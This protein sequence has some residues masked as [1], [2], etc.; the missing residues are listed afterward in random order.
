MGSDTMEDEG[1]DSCI[2]MAVRARFHAFIVHYI[3]IAGSDRVIDTPR[4][5]SD[6]YAAEHQ[7]ATFSLA[8]G[9]VQTF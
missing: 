6:V 1:A 5:S 4:I 3:F 9:P 2:G 7:T 8:R